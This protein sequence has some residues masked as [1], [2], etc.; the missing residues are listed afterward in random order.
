MTRWSSRRC[1]EAEDNETL[2]KKAGRSRRG[3]SAD[4]RGLRRRGMVVVDADRGNGPIGGRLEGT[5][6]ESKAMNEA[7]RGRH[8]QLGAPTPRDG[9]GGR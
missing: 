7:W 9:R 3:A 8:A 6:E 4:Q 2:L 5:G 1:G